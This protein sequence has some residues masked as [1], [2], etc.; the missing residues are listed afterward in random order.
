MS[1]IARLRQRLH[2]WAALRDAHCALDNSLE[3]LI[4]W[5]DSRAV[6]RKLGTR[7][8]TI[9]MAL[10]AGRKDAAQGI[11]AKLEQEIMEVLK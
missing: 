9:H 4:R 3:T 1:I 5:N 8:A 10:I 11:A 7:I 6:A 2:E